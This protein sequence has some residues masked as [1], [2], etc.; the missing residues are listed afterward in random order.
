MECIIDLLEGASDY[1]QHRCA[2]SRKRKRASKCS[3]T[4]SRK[5]SSKSLNGD[6]IQSTDLSVAGSPVREQDAHMDVDKDVPQCES[7]DDDVDPPIFLRHLIYGI[8]AV[9]KRLEDQSLRPPHMNVLTLPETSITPPK[10]LKYIFVCRADVDPPLLIE[11]LPHL[12][13]AYNSARPSQYAKLVPLPQGS[14]SLLAQILGI[15][16][17]TVLGIDVSSRHICASRP[18]C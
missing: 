7:H 1:R 4:L 17:V 6:A 15:R 5:K 14:E 9:T 10:P 12:V 8:N 11:H 3:E 18:L 16:R 13:A 2:S